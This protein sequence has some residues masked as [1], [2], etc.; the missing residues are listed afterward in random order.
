MKCKNQKDR[1]YYTDVLE[2]LLLSIICAASA[3]VPGNSAGGGL[4]VF[5]FLDKGQVLH[6]HLVVINHAIQFWWWTG[7]NLNSPFEWSFN[8]STILNHFSIGSKKKTQNIIKYYIYLHLLDVCCMFVQ[9]IKKLK[10]QPKSKLCQCCGH[11]A[12]LSQCQISET[13]WLS[14]VLF[15]N[16]ATSKQYLCVSGTLV[17]VLETSC[18][19]KDQFLQPLLGKVVKLHGESEGFLCYRLHTQTY[20]LYIYS[21]VV[22]SLES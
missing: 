22:I 17:S 4:E 9:V 15:C 21:F 13:I 12:D 6:W 10:S 14:A 2:K 3:S 18:F 16:C 20:I 8:H 5:M 1:K 19:L 7:K 11:V